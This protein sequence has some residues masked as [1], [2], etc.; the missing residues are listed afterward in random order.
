MKKQFQKTACKLNW[1]SILSF[2]SI[3]I[4]LMIPTG[5][6]A[7]SDSA[8][9]EVATAAEEAELISPSLDFISTQKS[10]NSIDL[11]AK[12]GGKVKGSFYKFPLLKISFVQVTDNDEKELG[13]VIT[14][15]AGKAVFNCKESDLLAYKDGKLHFKALFAGNKSMDPAEAELMIK[16]A[17]L[18]LDP[19]KEDSLYS[20]KLKLVDVGSGEE[21]AVPETE[22]GLFVKRSFKPLKIGEGTTDENGEAAI[23]V[24][25]KLPGNAKGNLTLIARLAE[26]ETYGNI[27]STATVNWGI[28]VS[29]LLQAAPRALWTSHPPIWMMVTFVVLMTVVWGHYFVIIFELFRLRKEEPHTKPGVTST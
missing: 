2:I 3:L 16:R 26:N 25:N 18:I 15:R 23:E 21:V 9:K 20:V 17:R 12:L 28:P 10:D 1:R 14:D 6:N 8:Q 13:A 19:V 7:Q 27:E 24:S 29:D 11:T 4:V 22:L 5:L